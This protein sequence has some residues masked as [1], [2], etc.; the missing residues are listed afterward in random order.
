MARH[1]CRKVEGAVL[2]RVA[3]PHRFWRVDSVHDHT[4]EDE[5]DAVDIGLFPEMPFVDRLLCLRV[6]VLALLWGEE[7]ECPEPI[8]VPTRIVD[9]RRT[10]LDR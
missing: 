6:E 7:A 5:A 1:G 2:S 8:V 3:Q 4:P 10:R 9:V